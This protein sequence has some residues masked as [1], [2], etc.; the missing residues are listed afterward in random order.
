MLMKRKQLRFIDYRLII[1]LIAA[2][3]I[4]MA[5]YSATSTSTPASAAAPTLSSIDI[6]PA[7]PPDLAVGNTRQFTATGTYA[8]GAAADITAQVTR[9]SDNAG[10]AA[11]DATGQ[12]TGKAAGTVNIKAVL[13]GITARRSV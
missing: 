4:V 10:T 11:I 1:G 7:Y 13:S 9:T 5:S 12:A 2:L 8:D 3:T 6:E